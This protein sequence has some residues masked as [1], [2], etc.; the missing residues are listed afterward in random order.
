MDKK[1]IRK[2]ILL[3][4]GV[5]VAISSTIFILLLDT[6]VKSTVYFLFGL[7]IFGLGGGLLQAIGALNSHDDENTSSW[8]ILLI[9]SFMDAILTLIILAVY[10]DSSFQSYITS[11]ETAFISKLMINASLYLTSFIAIVGTI[12]TFPLTIRVIREHFK[13]LSQLNNKKK[14]KIINI[15]EK[16]LSSFALVLVVLA[17]V[18]LIAFPLLSG[19]NSYTDKTGGVRIKYTIEYTVSNVGYLLGKTVDII[20]TT[21]AV[22]QLSSDAPIVTVDSMSIKLGFN[23]VV[24]LSFISAIIGSIA[25]FVL[26]LVKKTKDMMWVR[27]GFGLLSLF[28][29]LLSLFFSN[30]MIS[31]INSLVGSEVSY[32]NGIGLIMFSIL[33]IVG[34]IIFAILPAFEV[35]KDINNTY[36]DNEILKEE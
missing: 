6:Q 1:N 18:C 33:A 17:F 12:I 13:F 2:I 19:Q 35:K 23:F 24:Y 30:I 27:E 16:S 14:N 10:K 28:G 29:G 3:M 4:I 22:K 20:K 15:V 8:W 5:L 7:A 11:T 36:F 32:T 31:N 25:S 34:G 26:V 21:T 9:S